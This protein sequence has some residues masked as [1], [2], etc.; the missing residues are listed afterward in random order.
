VGESEPDNRSRLN[1][2][3]TKSKRSRANWLPPI[4]RWGLP[5]KAGAALRG[6]HSE[7]PSDD[8]RGEHPRGVCL[9]GVIKVGRGVNGTTVP[10][11]PR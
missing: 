3:R 11:T 7:F 1:S 9:T 10:F 6:R 5:W 4:F 2:R 8:F